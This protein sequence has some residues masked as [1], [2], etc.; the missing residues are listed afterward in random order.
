MNKLLP[1]LIL[2][3]ILL[4]SVACVLNRFNQGGTTT[5][6]ATLATYTPINP[7]TPVATQATVPPPSTPTP[8]QPT[9]PATATIQPSAGPATPTLSSTPP[10][11]GVAVDCD[12]LIEIKVLSAP[13][14]FNYLNLLKAKGRWLI[15]HLQLINL[16]G[17]TY[18]YLHENDFTIVSSGTGQS[19]VTMQN[20]DIE[21]Y[22][23]WAYKSYLVDPLPGAGTS[24][25]VVAFDV[26]P[27]IK[28][29]TFIFNPKESE[30][31]TTPFCMVE[32]PLH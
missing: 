23:V 9:P 12:N 5:I 15:L 32:I 11:I 7:S 8:P 26:D 27:T 21:A 10:G 1:I 4:F 16:T 3:F 18:N 30:Y 6:S 14:Y 2:A 29:W 17:E 13:S 22:L 28:D 31:S 20:S 25:R 19:V 24:P